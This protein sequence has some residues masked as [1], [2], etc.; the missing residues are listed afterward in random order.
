M[1]RL[2]QI[3]LILCRTYT[4]CL[5]EANSFLILACHRSQNILSRCRLSQR[6]TIVSCPALNFG[7]LFCRRGWTPTPWTSRRSRQSSS[8]RGSEY[9]SQPGAG[10]GVPARL[11]RV[12]ARLLHYTS[13]PAPA[14]TAK[15]TDKKML[16]VK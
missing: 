11:L 3:L 14:K 2:S 8:D 12:P 16:P 4:F 15:F 13:T 6:E 5:P 1:S 7:V 10:T 9:S